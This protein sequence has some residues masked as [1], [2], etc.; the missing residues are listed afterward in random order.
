M[1]KRHYRDIMRLYAY[2]GALVLAT[3][4]GWLLLALGA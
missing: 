1:N 2:W 3:L 4:G